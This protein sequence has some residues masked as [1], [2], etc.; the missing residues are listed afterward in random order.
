MSS[1]MTRNK[2]LKKW[3]Q[4]SV[5]LCQ[6]KEVVWIDGSKEQKKRLEDEAVK[7]GEILREHEKVQKNF[8]F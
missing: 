6:P 5:R 8:G 2:I 4:E 3:I 7:D 1:S